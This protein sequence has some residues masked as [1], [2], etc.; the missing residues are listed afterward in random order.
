ML[1]YMVD[2]SMVYHIVDYI[3]CYIEVDYTVVILHIVVDCNMV[4]D[5]YLL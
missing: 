5:L 2:Y 1:S 4:V 3:G